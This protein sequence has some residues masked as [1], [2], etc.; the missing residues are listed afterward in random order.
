MSK[1]IALLTL[2]VLISLINWSIYKKENHLKDGKIVYLKLAPVD[3]R[4]LMQG[5]YMALRY[6][7][8]NTIYSEL[9]KKDG[10]RFRAKVAAIDGDVI[11]TLD[12]Q[13]RGTFKALYNKQVL[14][15]NEML[16]HYRV[17]NGRVKLASNAF[18]FQEGTAKV[19]EKAKYGEFRVKDG[20]LLLA[21]MY[22]KNVKK[23]SPK[24]KGKE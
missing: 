24:P 18:F 20:V 9:P 15:E 3:P 17:R 23:L 6:D 10:R 14:K 11:V 4:S 2:V 21:N 5:D 13:R 16:L 12:A 19:Y 1:K 22:D 8:A 7:L